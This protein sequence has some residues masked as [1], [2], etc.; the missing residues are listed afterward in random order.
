MGCVSAEPGLRRR[1]A[2]Y[3]PPPWMRVQAVDPYDPRQIL[4][5][6]QPGLLAITDLA[7]IHTVSS[8]LT[9]DLGVSHG[10]GFEVWDVFQAVHS[11][12]AIFAGEYLIEA[13]RTRRSGR[14]NCPSF[15]R[16]L[17]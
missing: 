15:R 9:E 11:G 7:N 1:R 12:D 8:I 5:D 10:E 2:V 4:P 6:G 16:S 3:T 17:G 14:S 13:S